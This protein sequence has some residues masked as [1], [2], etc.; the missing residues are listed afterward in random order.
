MKKGFT[1]IELLSVI[2]IMAII[3]LIATPIVINLI[4]V[5][6]AG[7]KETS[8]KNYIEAVEQKIVSY[9]LANGEFMQNGVYNTIQS[10]IKKG[11]SIYDISIDG[12]VP[13]K[14]WLEIENGTII[15]YS[16]IIDG[17]TI[18]KD[19]DIEK[20]I[21][22]AER[23]LSWDW[24]HEDTNG[25]SQYDIGELISFGTEKFYIISTTTT[26]IKAL[27]RYNLYVGSIYVYGEGITAYGEE[28][29]GMQ[30]ETMKSANNGRI[31]RGT[32]PF[33]NSE[34]WT[35]KYYE[36]STIKQYVN[37]YG[38]KL[39][40]LGAIFD[41]LNL[42]EAGELL[43]LGC[44]GSH[45]Y[46]CTN[47][48]YAWTY[49]TPYWTKSIGESSTDLWCVTDYGSFANSYYGMNGIKGVRPVIIV[50]KELF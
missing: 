28:A 21:N 10:T 50:S 6:R 2:V 48:Q 41:S 30:D 34:L 5:A 47:S 40:N 3:A 49:S 38:D 27:S 4:E 36:T 44:Q 16:I 39:Q 18:T 29:T 32:V 13:S 35:T 22:L 24:Y 20:G 9:H 7:A 37:N 17:Y 12:E 25:N 19:E 1:L 23:P 46:T 15:D 26:S 14:G 33:G 42:I 31:I 8:A 43:Q 11:S 45:N